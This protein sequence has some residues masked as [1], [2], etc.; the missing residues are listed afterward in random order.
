MINMASFR[1]TFEASEQFES[2]VQQLIDQ[3]GKPSLHGVFPVYTREEAKKL[4][5]GWVNSFEA[6]ALLDKKK[7]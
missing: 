1:E 4:V 3:S 5:S 6:L 2:L 7:P